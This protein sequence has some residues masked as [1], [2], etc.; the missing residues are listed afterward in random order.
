M[1]SR[2]RQL[3]N[4]KRRR[5]EHILNVD[6]SQHDERHG[7]HG[8]VS[9]RGDIL[10]RNSVITADAHWHRRHAVSMLL[11]RSVDR[12][13]GKMEYLNYRQVEITKTAPRRRHGKCQGT[14]IAQ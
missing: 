12:D 14:F 2:V 10:R 3:L 4:Y 6:E 5:R 9:I 11:P 7:H 13:D 1:H 8:V